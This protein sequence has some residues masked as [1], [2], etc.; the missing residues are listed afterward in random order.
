MNKKSKLITVAALCCGGL[1][2]FNFYLGQVSKREVPEIPTAP[3][4][5]ATPPAEDAAQPFSVME[6]VGE[7]D[8]RLFSDIG[9]LTKGGTVSL[10]LP[11]GVQIAGTLNY[12]K[13]HPNNATAAG[14]TLA[15]G[16]GTFE[17]ARE[18]WGFRGFILQKKQKAAFVYSSDKDGKLQV[19][20]RPIG[21][22]MCEPDPD[23]KPLAA[24]NEPEAQ[25]AAIYNGGRSVGIIYEAIPIHHSLARAAAT[26]Y[27]DFDGEVIE[28]QSWEGGRRIIASAYNLPVSEITDMWR[29]V[30]EDFAPY[31]VNVT[32]D[33]Q[34]YWRAP[35]GRRMRCIITPSNFAPGAGGIAFNRTF[36]ESGDTCCWV[37]MTGK[38]G[39]DAISHE[40]G[41]TFNLG[42]DYTSSAGYY[43]GHGNGAASWGPIMGAPYG[44][45]VA[46]WSKGDY[47]DAQEH[48]DDIAYIGS[49]V[50]LK[51]DDHSSITAQATP[52]VLSSAG[53]VSNGGSIENAEDVDTFIFTTGGGAVNLQFAGAPPSPNLDIEAKL[54]NSAGTLVATS[55]PSNNLAATISTTLAAG[56]YTV[57]VD[58]VGNLTWMTGGYDDWASAGVYTISGSIAQ[59]NW[60]FRIPVNAV[61]GA[62]VGT[63]APGTGSA[64]SITAGNAGSAFAINASTGA[65]TVATPAALGSA[66]PFNLSIS[67][68]A[69]GSPVT[70]VVPISVAPLRGMKQ[71]IWTNPGG[72]AISNM[73]SLPTYPN[74][75]NLTRYSPSTQACCRL[76][77]YGQKLSAYLLPTET[78][79][80]VFW[81]NS[82]D[83]SELWLSTDANPA[84]KVK[85]SSNSSA[86]APGI[87]TAQGTQQSA[88][89]NLVAGQR[90]YLEILHRDISG[91][92]YVSASW[93]TPGRARHLIPNENLEY[94]GSLPNRQPWVAN[95]TFRV[96]ETSST[97]TV[98]GTLAA[99]DFE[100]GSSL[101]SFTITGGNSSGAFALNPTTGVLTVNGPL[102]FAT[103]QKYL[104][105]V[106]ATDSGGLSTTAQVAVEIEP[107]AV[108]RQLWTG[109]G[110]T[111]VASLTSLGVYPNNPSSTT[112]QAFFETPTNVSDNF[113]QKLSGY[114][115]APDTGS[116]TFWI[117]SDDHSELWLSTDGTPANK[118]MIASVGDWTNSRE[119]NKFPSQK[120]AA[121]SLQGGKFYYIEVLNKE[122]VGGDNLAVSW[123]GPDFGQVILGAPHVTQQFYNHAAPVLNDKN[124]T[125]F[126]RDDIVTTLEAKDWSDPG[127]TVTYSITAG[128]ADGA[129]TIDPLTGVIRRN[130]TQLPIG[131]RVLTVTASDNGTPVLSDTGIITVQIVKAAMKREVWKNLPGGGQAVTELTNSLHYPHT[132][133]ETGFAQNFEAP[134]N[135]ADN[136]GQRLSGFLVPPSTGNYT[137]WIASDD[138]SEL[139]LSSNADPANK[140]KICQVNGAVG[141]RSW[142]SQGN[143][144]SAVIPLVAGQYYYVEA[145]HKEGGGGDHVAVAWQGPSISQ[146]LITSNYLEYPETLRPALKREVW[147]GNTSTTPPARAAD[148]E[149]T[150]FSFK[151][152][153]DVAEN[154]SSRVTG[155]LIPPVTGAY[156]FWL[157][158]DDQGQ[159]FLSTDESSANLAQIA[160]IDTYSAEEAWDEFPSQKSVV[161]NL[162]AGRR[163]YVEARHREG[164]FGDHLAV[165]WQGPGIARQVIAN[166][167]LEHPSA[168]ADRTLFK[169]EV[170]SAVNG[171]ATADLKN[172]PNYP[173]S[174]STTGTLVAGA[175]LVAPSNIADNYGQRISGYLVA[176][177][178]GRYTFWI[179]SDDASELWLSTDEHPTNR[180]RIAYLDGVSDPQIWDAQPSQKSVPIHLATGRRYYLEVIHKEGGVTDHVAVAWQ[181]PSFDRRVIANGFMENPLVLPGQPNLKREVWADISGT[182]VSILTSTASFIAGKPDA[183]GALTTFESP[184]NHGENFGERVTGTLVAPE[185][186]DFKF[187][188]ASDV[189]SELWLSTDSNPS[190]RMKI[191]FTTSATAARNWTTFAS[192]ESGTLKLTAGQRYHIEVLHKESTGADQM[193]VAWQG[194]SFARQIIDGRFLEYPGTIPAPAALKREVWTGIGGNNVSNLTSNGSYPATPNLSETL[195]SFETPANASDNYGQ[196][197]SGYLIAPFTGD[198]QFWI[199]SDD[200]SELWFSTSDVQ[201]NKTRIA[202][203]NG[204]TGNKDW[205][206]NPSQAS[207][208]IA[209]TAGQ[210]CYIEALHKEG[211]GDDYLA[212]AWQGPGF[213]R[214]IIS[215]RFLEY[216]GLTP[217]VTQSGAVIPATGVDPGYTFW[218]SFMGLQGNDRLANADP[219]A[220]G[221]PNSL[222]FILGGLPS[223]V[224][225]NSI[226]LLPTITTD[227]DW[228]IFEFRRTDVSLAIDPFAQFGTTL[229][230][231]TRANDG[232]G[233][234]QI[235]TDDDGFGPGVDRVTVRVPRA[236]VPALFLRLNS[237]M[238]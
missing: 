83:S 82:D 162:V 1:A 167:F 178:D 207:A 234:V 237:N 63:V 213:A 122:G 159:L 147:Y 114:L 93:Q 190:N 46:Q 165:A 195:G 164:Q 193:S 42:H 38:A 67:Y 21:E 161:K 24:S 233:G 99:G 197:V 139:W 175:G 229:D 48:Q 185:S 145:L 154:F 15:D 26:I 131:T 166:N 14:G 94:P 81:I 27:L 132:R 95:M 45:N 124:V 4:L 200:G 220:D 3:V 219:D 158:S 89:V 188:I 130:N 6:T 2:T 203:A 192:Q 151:V 53:A 226:S 143:Q 150:L 134:A 125:M 123:S 12:V 196:K 59:P 18:P 103:L 111:T 221:V 128:N 85:I 142:T 209:L 172:S 101:S 84:N 232:M 141:V 183:R 35:Q 68:T 110:G 36:I 157:A 105:D 8:G 39:S 118:V 98:V 127:T 160:S 135:V 137:F 227:V 91:D 16:S 191:A 54:Y 206:D 40:V 107:L 153:K 156:T 76:N 177:E 120:S 77:G 126:T 129:F 96:G 49:V 62:A 34:A 71:E 69:A 198:Y 208:M 30:A 10:P 236:G 133:D 102:S 211:G 5:A 86:L 51:S 138:G 202:Y 144:Q 113:G 29:R 222:E 97:G 119:W 75:P 238:R 180:L 47:P 72:T 37:F 17:I 174:P 65:I 186:G 23:W 44:Y 121:I 79:S 224:A 55:S 194:P 199:A 182:A 43:G 223:G 60:R 13:T 74:S 56:T 210:R 115:R 169:R 41:H 205:T 87:W 155:Y 201:A 173:A 52:L 64:Y 168:P 58:G 230:D 117:A 90:Y 25:E 152:P 225:A 116:Y 7:Q 106:S 228:A 66:G 163:Y 170:W 235:I 231:W 92:E 148:F 11:G 136:Y 171:G 212:V 57:T 217:A 61:A 33:A 215:S 112:Y 19:A 104:L 32:T 31:E 100:A 80:H 149:G 88:P 50:P 73:T 214:Q 22:V 146:S 108:K 176:P 216:P 187:W 78:G 181:G 9:A 28:G 179:A 20:R 218:L 204:A 70:A 109:V 184:V 140:R 189:A